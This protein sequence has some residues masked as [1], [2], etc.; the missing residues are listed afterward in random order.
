VNSGSDLISGREGDGDGG[1]VDGETPGENA[2]KDNHSLGFSSEEVGRKG[3]KTLPGGKRRGEG[4]W[5]GQEE[6]NGL[7]SGSKTCESRIF[8]TL[9]N[10]KK[11]QEWCGCSKWGRKKEGL[12]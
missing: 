10:K 3:S 2:T 6:F 8:S 9:G 1:S 7:L 5:S 12:D 4:Y 11:N